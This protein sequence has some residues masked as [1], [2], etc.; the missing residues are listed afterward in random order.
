MT[1]LPATAL[2]L[3]G[4]VSEQSLRG[5]VPRAV[6]ALGQGI[7]ADTSGAEYEVREDC[8]PPAAPVVGRQLLAATLQSA[9]L[10]QP[11]TLQTVPLLRA[12]FWGQ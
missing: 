4:S 10:L 8:G 3:Q 7:A 6:Q 5:M 12:V 2:C 11:V 1:L 9:C